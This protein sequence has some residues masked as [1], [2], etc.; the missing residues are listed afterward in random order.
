MDKVEKTYD[1]PLD[2]NP[3]WLCQLYLVLAVGL[4]MRRNT[5][6]PNATE[7]RILSRLGAERTPRAEIFFLT[8][9]HLND[10]VYGFEEGGIEAVQS[11]LLMAVYMLT[12][13]KRNTAWVY[14][15]MIITLYIYASI[16]N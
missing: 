3:A 15:G 14:I 13:S 10:S 6:N 8:A 4:Q 7:S 9:K 12:A 16:T 11:L 5:S 1:Q 2:A